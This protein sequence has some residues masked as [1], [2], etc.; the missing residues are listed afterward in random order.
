[1]TTVFIS[2]SA[3][4]RKVAERVAKRLESGGC[5]TYFL[6]VDPDQGI[7]GGQD[8]EEA[9]YQNL[10]ACRTLLVLWSS[11]AANSRWVFA[12][13]AVAKALGK[14]VFP[15]RLDSS[16]LPNFISARQA[17]DLPTDEEA[18]ARMLRLLEGASSWEGA[19]AFTWDR[20]R[21]PYPGLKA[22][23]KEDAGVFFGRDELIQ[24]AQERIRAFRRTGTGKLLL[25]LGPSGS[26]KSSFVRAGLLP[27]LERE[28]EWIILS[29]FRPR[30]STAADPFE[31]ISRTFAERL[32][33]LGDSRTTA[34]IR[35]MLWEASAIPAD[36]SAVLCRFAD[37]LR[38]R[39]GQRNASILITVDQFEELLSGDG[40]S[41]LSERFLHLMSAISRTVASHLTVLAT[42]RSDFLP[43]LNRH[44]A[45][46][47][48][49]TEYFQV[50]PLAAEDWSHIIE[51][52]AARAGVL[53]ERRLT[54]ALVRETG[55]EDALPLLAFTL[56]S[57]WRKRSGGQLTYD[58]YLRSGGLEKSIA[59]AAEDAFSAEPLSVEEMTEARGAFTSLVTVGQGE[60]FVRRSIRWD[61][62][63]L[64]ARRMLTCFIQNRLIVLRHRERGLEIEF[65]HDAVLHSWA[66]LTAV[67]T[68]VRPDPP[69]RR[70]G[71]T[72]QAEITEQT[73]PRIV[74][75]R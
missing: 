57:L 31:E 15:V 19:D 51:G 50:P 75:F 72:E 43:E 66:R 54:D 2:H 17:I 20:E 32:A 56:E 62:L 53:V 14:K 67:F 74:W 45:A 52:P 59:T 5:R 38:E 69:S 27:S 42:L 35:Q 40:D 12:E 21:S 34:E 25:V 4:D 48:L 68:C 49:A 36:A 11:S 23:E 6:D 61:D 46:R 41:D 44:V 47:E 30:A 28:P 16:A 71:K 33:P 9:L 7:T 63:P 29:P 22:M 73:E 70:G 55:S 26:G 60:R 3:A 10:R 13:V 58:A 1:M 24:D 18:F 64:A 8:W 37:A 39:S 65:A